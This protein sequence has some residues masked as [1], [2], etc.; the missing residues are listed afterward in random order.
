MSQTVPLPP[1][2]AGAQLDTSDAIY[3]DVDD[4]Q[5][6]CRIS[7]TTAWRLIRTEPDF[8]PPVVLGPKS[9][10]WPRREVVAFM[11]ARRRAGYY[12]SADAQAQH[13]A[14]LRETLYISRPVRQGHRSADDGD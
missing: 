1:G 14:M 6:H 9:L 13:G 11:E 7:R 2:R 8:P 4:I 3:W 10:V 12:A 5:H